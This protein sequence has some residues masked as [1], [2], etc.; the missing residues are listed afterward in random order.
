MSCRERPDQ[1]DNCYHGEHEREK[2]AEC[3]IGLGQTARYRGEAGGLLRGYSFEGLE[4]HNNE[5]K[6]QSAREDRSPKERLSLAI[7]AK[8]IPHLGPRDCHRV[9][10]KSSV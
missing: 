4:K 6:G 8:A 3:H 2:E 1:Q 7:V 5:W 10:R 9:E